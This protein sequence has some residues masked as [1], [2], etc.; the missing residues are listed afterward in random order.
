[1]TGIILALPRAT[2]ESRFLRMIGVFVCLVVSAVLSNSFMRFVMREGVEL[3]STVQN[4]HSGWREFNGRFQR[5]A[6]RE[7]PL[8]NDR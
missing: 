1:M 2:I 8:G 4:W 5:P 7:Q 3:S 6:W